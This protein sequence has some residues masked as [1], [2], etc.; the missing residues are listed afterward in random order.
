M[1]RLT[2]IVI[3]IAEATALGSP[4]WGQS[5]PC[6]QGPPVVI[7]GA[8]TPSAVP[9]EGGRYSFHQPPTFSSNFL[10]P[11]YTAPRLDIRRS[12]PPGP[13]Y[14]TPTAPYT[15]AYYGYYY[16]PGYFRY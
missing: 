10:A 9:F 11:G 4:A 3:V 8:P 13:Y 16:T 7:L 14:F 5:P 6:C 1:K 15:P 2:T 12:L